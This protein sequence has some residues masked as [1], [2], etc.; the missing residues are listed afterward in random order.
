MSKVTNLTN[1]S[2]VS[3]TESKNDVSLPSQIP[4]NEKHNTGEMTIEE[5]RKK[6][7]S[8]YLNS[9]G[10]V[11]GNVVQGVIEV[12][13]GILRGDWVK[14]TVQSITGVCKGIWQDMPSFTLP[15]AQA[16]TTKKDIQSEIMTRLNTMR[17][18]G[19]FSI[20]L[21]PE[22]EN[23]EAMSYNSSVIKAFLTFAESS[24]H[25]FDLAKKCLDKQP[26]IIFVHPEYSGDIPEDKGIEIKSGP[27]ASYWPEINTLVIHGNDPNCIKNI[28]LRIC[29]Y[30]KEDY[31]KKTSKT[32]EQLHEI[33]AHRVHVTIDQQVKED[34]EKDPAL[35]KK[36]SEDTK[37]YSRTIT[38]KLM[39]LAKQS[40]YDQDLV[41]EC[42]GGGGIVI[43]HPQYSKNSIKSEQLGDQRHQKILGRSNKGSGDQ[44][45]QK[46]LGHYNKGDDS[47]ILLDDKHNINDLRLICKNTLAYRNNNPLLHAIQSGDNMGF[48]TSTYNQESKGNKQNMGYRI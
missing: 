35:N 12:C 5:F 45:H 40:L 36:I 33:I 44:G 6:L 39:L 43:F 4:T 47:I 28:C 9:E 26:N 1:V 27:T 34:M 18:E 22:V 24:S 23:K 8:G 32:F 46:I 14:N 7:N 16:L 13:K 17:D 15:G 48:F 31:L 25:H 19:K 21:D 2:N 3:Y 37:K 41:E 30:K 42:L 20:L 29:D 11:L 38:S 10:D